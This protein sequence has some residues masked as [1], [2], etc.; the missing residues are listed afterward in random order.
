MFAEFDS[1]LFAFT[2]LHRFTEIFMIAPAGGLCTACRHNQ[3][4]QRKQMRKIAKFF[5]GFSGVPG[6]RPRT[7]LDD[8]L[9]ENLT[10]SELDVS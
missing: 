8:E 6:M 1:S 9:D 5:L 3:Q 4:Q 7:R 10:R 2:D